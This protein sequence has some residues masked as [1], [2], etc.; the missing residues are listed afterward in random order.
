MPLPP[1]LWTSIKL[2]PKHTST[3]LIIY[4]SSYHHHHQYHMYKHRIL[5]TKNKTTTNISLEISGHNHRHNTTLK[6]TPS[7]IK[8]QKDTVEDP[9]SATSSKA[10]PPSPKISYHHNQEAHQTPLNGPR[11]STIS[12]KNMIALTKCQILKLLLYQG[13]YHIRN[14]W[15]KLKKHWRILD[16]GLL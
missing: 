14:S 5:T 6:I 11:S 8:N 2:F 7:N 1:T 16:V 15:R 10:S 9:H 13:I 4:H 3:P 12:Q